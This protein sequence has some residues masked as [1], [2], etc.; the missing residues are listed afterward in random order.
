MLLQEI[1]QYAWHYPLSDVSFYLAKFLTKFRFL[2]FWLKDSPDTFL[3]QFQTVQNESKASLHPNC[4]LV[5][6]FVK[7]PL[8]PVLLCYFQI[9]G[10]S[11]CIPSNT[12]CRILC[13]KFVWQTLSSTCFVPL[14]YASLDFNPFSEVP[15][16]ALKLTHAHALRHVSRA[17]SLSKLEKIRVR[18]LLKYL[19]ILA[20]AGSPNNEG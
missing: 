15:F 5:F 7:L 12:R 19:R 6:R 11:F 9:F 1:K 2:E 8:L 10:K 13:V 4:F 16:I 14:I 3:I 18:Q 20:I 17:Q